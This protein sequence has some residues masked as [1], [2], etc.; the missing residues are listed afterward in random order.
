[1]DYLWKIIDISKS[2]FYNDNNNDNNDNQYS[3]LILINTYKSVKIYT[4]P[5][6]TFEHI[7]IKI[8]EETHIPYGLQRLFYKGFELNNEKTPHNYYID[9]NS[10]I[11]LEI[12]LKTKIIIKYHNNK[13]IKFEELNITY[14][15]EYIKFKI[16]KK[17]NIHIS[18]QR[19]FYKNQELENDKPLTYYNICNEFDPTLDL[20]IGPKNGILIYIKFLP[21]E[22]LKF[23]FLPSTKIGFIKEKIY[24]RVFFLPETQIL[25][26]NNK[27]L[28]N[29][30]NLSDYYIT[31][32]STLKVNFISKNGI[33]IFIKRPN[34]KIFPFDISISETILNLKKKISKEED[35]PVDNLEMEYNNIKLDN[36][37]ALL[38]Y[39]IPSQS[40]IE[41]YF[42]NNDGFQLFVKTLTGK[43]ITLSAQPY[44]KVI[45]IKEMIKLREG[46]PMDEQRLVFS[47]IALEDNRTIAYF[48][49]QKESTI[50]L[51][52]RLR[53]GKGII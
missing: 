24:E 53:G 22:I 48:D 41:A 13:K 29:N 38:D 35:I 51:V 15:V 42:Y 10:I 18:E 2:Y 40:I 44:Y 33:V 49:I 43:T 28:N 12:D 34:E 25:L 11:N 19:L 20:F 26:F 16:E 3:L 32:K 5:S 50:H 45:Y 6:E 36:K 21:E 46:I 9:K 39:N 14:K 7:K 37:K 27:E 17:L 30:K 47:G 8:N 52:L 4:E 31:N 1:M 23:S